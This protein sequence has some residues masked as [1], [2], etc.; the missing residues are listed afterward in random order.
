[1]SAG[2]SLIS[3]FSGVHSQTPIRDIT[4][5]E[6]VGY[7]SSQKAFSILAPIRAEKDKDRRAQLK[8]QLQAVTI[9]ATFST[10][11]KN[12]ALADK[13]TSYN[14]IVCIDLDS[15]PGEPRHMTSEEA[16]YWLPRVRELPY[17]WY[18]S[19]SASGC[20]IYAYA[21]TNNTD[22]RQ[23]ETYW[24]ALAD[25]VRERL[26][27]EMD[28]NTKDVT[29][30]RY[31]SYGEYIVNENAQPFI[32]PP[33]YEIP[34]RTMPDE[35]TAPVEI[36]PQTTIDA[37]ACVAEFER[38][39]IILGDG[40]YQARYNLGTALKWLP[41]GL[42]LY[43]R[44]CAGAQHH[45]T[46]EEEFR[47]FPAPKEKPAPGEKTISMGTFFFVMRA[48]Y[49]I[50][51]PEPE[52]HLPLDGLAP[53]IRSIID[54]VASA[55]QCPPEFVV[56]SMYAAIAGVAGKKFSLVNQAYTNHAQLWVA[57]LAYAGDGK[58]PQMAYMMRPVVDLDTE[59]ER[60]YAAELQKWEGGDKSTPPPVCPAYI[61]SDATPEA[62]DMALYENPNGAIMFV[63]ELSQML[64]DFG[65]YNQSGE[66]ERWLAIATNATLKV[67]RKT[68]KTLIVPEAV[69]SIYG[70]TQPDTVA[71][72]FGAP[73]F[74]NRGFYGRWLW[75]WPTPVKRTYQGAHA[76]TPTTERNWTRIIQNLAKSPGAK[77]TLSGDAD[78]MFGDWWNT[79][80]ERRAALPKNDPMR[81]VLGKMPMHALRWALITQ[82]LADAV[83]EP[84]ITPDVMAHTLKC[85]EYF[86]QNARKVVTL[87]R[88]TTRTTSTRITTDAA[89]Q[90]L[91]KTH[92]ALNERGHRKM[93]ADA[94]GVSDVH[95]Y[96]A[97]AR[98]GKDSP[99]GGEGMIRKSL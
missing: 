77:Y 54:D 93:L 23:H 27:L 84:E 68:Q 17:V 75:L 35:W 66:V 34:R 60:R 73:Q 72:V 29:R 70:G 56:G 63:D 99:L 30:T 61:I 57:A 26:G 18:A 16:V 46:P 22:Y 88:K 55:Y 80:E 67:K 97:I 11:D 4:L 52:Y 10:R 31:L 82:I 71:R 8:E 21:L 33:G 58:S 43:R 81:E 5:D 64:A 24:Y 45:R 39:G 12:V 40:T 53:A 2:V 41:N 85:M 94:L 79:N 50:V 38:R 96:R 87:L 62:R 32:L 44:L 37:E 14:G 13:L 74:A 91:A 28:T 98:G 36:T 7:C 59:I 42:E 49:K 25:D 92:P 47:G 3:L 20:G 9:S 83:D 89:I 76:P 69:C 1:M 6:W 65:R 86:E 19:L 15:P 95:I 78:A 90:H 48:D 51:P